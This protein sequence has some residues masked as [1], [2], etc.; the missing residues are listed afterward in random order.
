MGQTD[1]TETDLKADREV[2]LAMAE[3]WSGQEH[4]RTSR[5]NALFHLQTTVHR[6]DSLL[7][8]FI[9]FDPVPTL[10]ADDLAHLPED[11]PE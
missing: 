5:H 6:L 4:M 2:L 3:R 8:E 9:G 10:P 1:N 11:T 7:A